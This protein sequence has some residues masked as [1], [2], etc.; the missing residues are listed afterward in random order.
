VLEDEF[1]KEIEPKNIQ[2][3]IIGYYKGY[4]KTGQFIIDIDIKSSDCSA[5][6]KGSGNYNDGDV[7]IG[8]PPLSDPKPE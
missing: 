6:R 5:V 7:A 1:I 8:A 4:F 3:N 2:I